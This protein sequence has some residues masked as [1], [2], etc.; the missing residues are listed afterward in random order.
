VSESVSEP[1]HD[2]NNGDHAT[3]GGTQASDGKLVE[4]GACVLGVWLQN[5]ADK[6][7]ARV[8]LLWRAPSILHS[9]VKGGAPT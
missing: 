4:A 2:D 1:R 6:R 7:P 9:G 5:E 8:A 3:M